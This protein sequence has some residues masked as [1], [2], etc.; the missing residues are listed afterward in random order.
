M[1][2]IK[3]DA[4]DPNIFRYVGNDPI[5]LTDPWGLDGWTIGPAT[6]PWNVG[7]YIPGQWEHEAE[8]RRQFWDGRRF[9]EPNWKLEQ[10]AF[11][12]QAEALKN[13]ID[14][15]KNRGACPSQALLAAYEDS[16]WAATESGAKAYQEQ[17]DQANPVR[18]MLKYITK[19]LFK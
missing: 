3:F 12:K 14:D 7:D 2:P 13:K 8:H 17:V 19:T 11:K 18:N 6:L 15:I 9:T 16:M 4:G 10:E 1:D 5:N